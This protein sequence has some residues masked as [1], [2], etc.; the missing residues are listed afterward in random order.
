MLFHG[1][2]SYMDDVNKNNRGASP[3]H[4]SGMSEVSVANG[5]CVWRPLMGHLKDD[6]YSFA[7]RYGVPYFKDSTPSWSTRGKLRNHL[8]PLLRDMYGDGCLSN[9]TALAHSSDEHHDLV[10][11]NLYEPFL[12]YVF[13]DTHMYLYHT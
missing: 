7:H 12:R 10:Q 11:S 13:N 5:V 9:L 6:I 3:L 8:I 4:L 2:A 1:T